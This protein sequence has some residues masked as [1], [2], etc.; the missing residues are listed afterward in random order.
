M[1]AGSTRRITPDEYKKHRKPT[2]EFLEE[3]KIK[4]ATLMDS[5]YLS[6]GYSHTV[7]GSQLNWSLDGKTITVTRDN[8]VLQNWEVVKVDRGGGLINISYRIMG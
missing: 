4:T 6:P 1:V 2:K 5:V 3:P 8:K 7:G